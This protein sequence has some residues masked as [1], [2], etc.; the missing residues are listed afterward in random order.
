ME[1]RQCFIF[2]S[3]LIYDHSHQKNIFRYT[4]IRL[5]CVQESTVDMPTV[6]SMISMLSSE[7]MGIPP[8][9]QQTSLLRQNMMNTISSKERNVL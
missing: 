9:R 8:V 2:N 3:T 6:V 1:G 4:H 5:F 7:I